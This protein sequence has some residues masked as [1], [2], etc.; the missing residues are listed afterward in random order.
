VA[1]GGTV[2]GSTVVLRVTNNRN[3][4]VQA[5]YPASW[6]VLRQRPL[7]P[8]TSAII[9]ALRAGGGSTVIIPGGQTVEFTLPGRTVSGQVTL[10]PGATGYAVTAL[11]LAVTALGISYGSV[12]GAP[13][14]SQAA[15]ARVVSSA[16]AGQACRRALLASGDPR[17]AGQAF[18]LLS[19]DVAAALGCLE[20]AW[21]AEYPGSA[22]LRSFLAAVAAWT[23]RSTARFTAGLAAL[24]EPAIYWQPVLAP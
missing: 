16:V 9:S 15:S 7:D 8:V 22:L 4:A 2:A 17:T 19:A 20:P 13:R 21:Q 10:W 11:G 23:A 3:Y 14:I 5:R 18:S 24:V 1:P 12:P 6:S